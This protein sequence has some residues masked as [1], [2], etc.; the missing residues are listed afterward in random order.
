[1]LVV[2]DI[3]ADPTLE[4]RPVDADG[5]PLSQGELVSKMLGHEAIRLVISALGTGIRETFDVA[6]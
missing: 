3:E 5:T 4:M 6:A 1:M 2:R